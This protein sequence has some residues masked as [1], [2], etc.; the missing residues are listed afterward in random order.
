MH[1]IVVGGKEH[2]VGSLEPCR[3][4]TSHILCSFFTSTRSAPC[5]CIASAMYYPD[6]VGC[7]PFTNNGCQ[8]SL[9]LLLKVQSSCILPGQYST[10]RMCRLKRLRR[11]HPSAS[12]CSLA[13]SMVTFSLCSNVATGLL[14]GTTKNRPRLS[15]CSRLGG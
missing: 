12:N 14:T 13:P 6:L 10:M 15:L 9:G 3:L 1:P 2:T 11:P 8:M 7:Y 5:V 4:S